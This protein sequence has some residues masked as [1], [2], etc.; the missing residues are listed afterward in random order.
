[1]D[2]PIPRS[3]Q[4]NSS[5]KSNLLLYMALCLSSHAEEQQAQLLQELEQHQQQMLQ[6]YDRR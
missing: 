3:A 5:L 2:L 6:E 1:M 4:G